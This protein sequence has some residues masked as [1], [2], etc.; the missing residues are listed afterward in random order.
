VEVT[1]ASDPP[2][3]LVLIFQAYS[4]SS[5]TTVAKRIPIPKDGGPDVPL[6]QERLRQRCPGAA[7]YLVTRAL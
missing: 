5:P 4:G 7:I 3:R 2:V 6:L 1:A